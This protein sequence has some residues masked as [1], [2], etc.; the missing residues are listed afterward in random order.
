MFQARS[1]EGAVNKIC[2]LSR[3]FSVF[4]SNRR[5]PSITNLA[6]T[7]WLKLLNLILEYEEGNFSDISATRIFQID[8]MKMSGGYY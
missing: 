2:V 7:I 3:N 6:L 5:T 8:E 4:L 1:V